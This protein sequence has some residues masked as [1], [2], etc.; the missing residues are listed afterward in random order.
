MAVPTGRPGG[1]T[2]PPPPTVPGGSSVS[3]PPPDRAGAAARPVRSRPPGPR[4]SGSRLRRSLLSGLAGVAVVAVAA[5]LP[6]A[7]VS[8]A[9]EPG[10][11]RIL[12]ADWFTSGG[13][14]FLNVEA[15]A[16]VPDGQATLTAA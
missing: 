5:S 2:G 1:A 11:L 4:W 9:E 16:G 7:P 3:T 14:T 8:A 10:P 15:K 13:S 6:A 12:R